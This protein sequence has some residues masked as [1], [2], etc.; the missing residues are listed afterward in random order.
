M[1]KL[2]PDRPARPTCGTDTRYSA[3]LIYGSG[4]RADLMLPDGT[5]IP[6]G[7]HV[8]P[9]AEVNVG[10]SHEIKQPDGKPITVR[11]D[12]VNLFDTIYQIRNGSGVGVFAPQFGMRRGFFAGIS[13]RL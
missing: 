5:S 9:Y 3:D 8:A 4:L 11:F 6:N 13:K 1:R 10:I 7:D 12:V 2:G